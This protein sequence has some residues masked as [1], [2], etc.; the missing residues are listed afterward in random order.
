MAAS[1]LESGNSILSLPSLSTNQQ[2][3]DLRSDTHNAERVGR[4]RSVPKASMMAQRVYDGTR[5]SGARSHETQRPRIIKCVT[6]DR[7]HVI[8]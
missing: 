6:E 2:V 3:S 1:V 7:R 8:I 5:S 4:L